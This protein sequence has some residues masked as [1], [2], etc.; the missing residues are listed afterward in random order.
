VAKS[1]YKRGGESIRA[2]H[3]HSRLVDELPLVIEPSSPF[4]GMLNYLPDSSSRGYSSHIFDSGADDVLVGWL[5]PWLIPMSVCHESKT[6]TT[7]VASPKSALFLYG[8]EEINLIPNFGSRLLI[9]MALRV[10]TRLAEIMKFENFAFIHNSLLTTNILERI[11]LPDTLDAARR[12]NRDFPGHYVGI[13]SISG[14]INRGLHDALAE[15]GFRMIAARSIYICKDPLQ[16]LHRRR[17]HIRDSMLIEK[18]HLRF[19]KPVSDADFHTIAEL[20]RLLYINKHSALNPHYSAQYFQCAM[21][22]RFLSII[23]IMREDAIIIGFIAF[24]RTAKVLSIPSMGYDPKGGD[25]FVYRALM[26]YAFR[27]AARNE[28]TLHLSAGAASFKRSRGAIQE[29]EWMAVY[30]KNLHVVQRW[31]IRLL[32]YFS[33]K[34][35]APIM[36]R[37]RI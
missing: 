35:A 6:A 15:G 27:V 1:A 36:L 8:L 18:H 24:H 37:Y 23:L 33:T 34:I 19:R 12:I 20:Y 11:S 9:R 2:G 30:L 13:R 32:S 28:L 5:E 25:T 26:N 3:E 31:F 21:K 17:D 16:Q 7:F 22:S 4:V 14:S 10:G 29:I